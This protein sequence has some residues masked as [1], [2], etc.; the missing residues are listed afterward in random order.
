MPGDQKNLK[1]RDPRAS[2]DSS[3]L[4]ELQKRMTLFLSG[5][6][7]VGGV[8][9]TDQNRALLKAILEKVTPKIA[10]GAT[11]MAIIQAFANI[12]VTAERMAQI[13]QGDPY[14]E[15][16]FQRVVA[17]MSKREQPPS[18][19]AA[20]VLMGI[21]N[22]RNLIVANQILRS[23]KSGFPEWTKEG[24]LKVLSS[25]FVKFGLKTEESLVAKKDPMSDLGFVAGLIFD[26]LLQ[27]AQEDAEE[28]KKVLALI[29]AIYDHGM[30][31]AGYGAVLA[32]SLSGFPY[33][34]FVFPICLL[35]DVGKIVMAIFDKRY[36]AF[37]DEM[38]KK[39]VPRPLRHRLERDRF[40]VDHAFIG[41][42]VIR[43]YPPFR[44]LSGA[45]LL[46]HSPFWGEGG[47]QSKSTTTTQ[48]LR[49]LAA[50]IS[51]SSN[52]ASKAKKIDNPADPIIA[53]W[54]GSELRD[55][56]FPNDAIVAA[57]QITT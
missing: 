14:F 34:K 36:L 6:S 45:V 15:D 18:V 12:D 51:L 38:A 44:A 52:M 22:S 1:Y 27:L 29:D 37:L 25:D 33:T 41:S 40:G 4:E 46:H 23:V 17:S 32:R 10:L 56:D 21:Q 11:S 49:Q 3:G 5:S 50:V 31:S 26:V 7:V 54:R 28:K 57:S 19:E 48:G 55:F 16:L 8:S 20:I 42:T 2:L 9:E 13:I 43:A 35:H 47:G 30:K 24:K 39:D 53:I